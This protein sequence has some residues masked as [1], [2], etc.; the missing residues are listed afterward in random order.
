MKYTPTTTY[1]FI[2]F[3]DWIIDNNLTPLMVIDTTV[4]GVDIPEDIFELIYA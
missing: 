2:G 1:L 4:E 3:Y